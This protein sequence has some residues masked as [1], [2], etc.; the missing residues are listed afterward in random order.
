[1]HEI[2]HQKA[3]DNRVQAY[4]MYVCSL[5]EIREARGDMHYDLLSRTGDD[6][7]GGMSPFSRLA[8][9]SLPAREQKY[10]VVP[11]KDWQEGGRRGKAYLA[12]SHGRRRV[13]QREA[14][15][16]RQRQDV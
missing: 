3:H 7:G 1:M 16:C 4:G 15:S 8:I 5:T 9:H 13:P 10:Q 11:G 6:D 12:G 2:P 14:A